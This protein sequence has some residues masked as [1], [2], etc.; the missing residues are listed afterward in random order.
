MAG[1]TAEEAYSWG[2]GEGE[3]EIGGWRFNG[4]F[5]CRIRDCSLGCAEVKYLYVSLDVR[6]NC[7]LNSRSTR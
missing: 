1:H 4:G 6:P 7:E 2:R 3:R 5:C